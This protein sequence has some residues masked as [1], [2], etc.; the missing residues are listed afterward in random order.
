MTG[1]RIVVM[2]FEDF[3]AKFVVLGDVDEFVM[4]QEAVLTP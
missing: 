3:K 1:E 2:H 4:K